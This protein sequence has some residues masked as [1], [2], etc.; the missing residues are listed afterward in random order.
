[1]MTKAKEGIMS[2]NSHNKT[3]DLDARWE[4]TPLPP[5]RWPHYDP[6]SNLPRLEEALP[7]AALSC[8]SWAIS[9]WFWWYWRALSRSWGS[10]KQN[11]YILITT[12]FI[13]EYLVLQL[14]TPFR[15]FY[16]NLHAS[17]GVPETSICPHLNCSVSEL[18][19]QLQ[20]SRMVRY[21]LVKVPLGVVSTAQ[22]AVCSCLLT[23]VLQTLPNTP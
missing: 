8:R 14:T 12:W 21:G 17:G 1:M 19:G 20:N 3:P 13:N 5:A 9:S 22:V 11:D 15:S 2:Y 6:A 16:T 18:L 4:K 23:L 10:V 7:C